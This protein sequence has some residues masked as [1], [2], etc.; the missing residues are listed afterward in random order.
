MAQEVVIDTYEC[1]GCGGCVDI[2]PEVFAFQDGDEHAHVIRPEAV[3]LDCVQ[4]IMVLCPPK[5]I[6]IE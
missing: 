2:C 6:H 5:C 4:E 1:N 3:D